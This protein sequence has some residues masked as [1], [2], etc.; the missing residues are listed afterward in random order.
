MPALEKSSSASKNYCRVLTYG[1]R[2]ANDPNVGFSLTEYDTYIK[3]Y[4][5]DTGLLVSHAFDE[6]ELPEVEVYNQI[7][8]GI[9]GLNEGMLCEIVIARMLI[10]NGH[11]LFFYTHFSDENLIR[12]GN[13][14]N[15]PNGEFIRCPG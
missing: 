2:R 8:A 13:N 6:N 3:C 4:M 11:R 10:S 1:Y 7:L 14:G 5:G 12:A 9:L 15:K